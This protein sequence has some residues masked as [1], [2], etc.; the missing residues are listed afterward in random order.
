M[1]SD[2]EDI[3]PSYT[4]KGREYFNRTLAARYVDMTDTGFRKKIKRI[5][6]DYGFIIPKISRGGLQKLIDKRILDQFRKPIF[7]GQEQKWV[8]E[9]KQVCEQI[10]GEQ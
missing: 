2:N 5:E 10:V 1:A 8:E 9:L 4:N 7:V 3:R 6:T